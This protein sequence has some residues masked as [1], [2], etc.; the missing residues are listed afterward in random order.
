M[1]RKLRIALLALLAALVL[2]A[3]AS[4]QTF[5]ALTGR[6]VDDAGML[7]PGTR[8]STRELAE[9]EEKTAHQ[10]VIVTV[11]SLEGRSIEDYGVRLGRAWQIGQKGK[12]DG[13]LLIVAPNERKVRIEVGYGLEGELTDAVAK[14]I[15]EERIL[16]NFRKGDMVAGVVSGSD[17]IRRVLSGESAEW[18]RRAAR[19]HSTF[20]G[21]V[22]GFGVEAVLSVGGFFVS[23]LFVFLLGAILSLISLAWLRLCLPVI[24]SVGIALGLMSKDR[25]RWLARR[26]AKWHFL[27]LTDSN[28]RRR[29][30]VGLVVG[31]GCIGGRRL[32]GRRRQLRRRRCIRELVEPCARC[33]RSKSSC[34][35]CSPR[36]PSWRPRPPRAIRRSPAAWSTRPTSSIIRRARPS[37]RC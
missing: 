16:P 22:L 13:V 28:A 31:I 33:E 12:N 9:L 2:A 6:V 14:L 7:S 27:K 35:L 36:S 37:P 8:A 10:L 34:S 1:L 25:R 32:F 18:K 21:H 29:P 23:I 20:L 11:K 4:A 26:Q 5:P 3:P 15:I 17:S 24:V 30:G 19:T